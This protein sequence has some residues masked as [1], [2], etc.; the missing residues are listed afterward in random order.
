MEYVD[1]PDL[2][3]VLKALRVRDALMPIPLV[4]YI[5]AELAAALDVAHSACDEAG[6]PLGIV[7]RDVSPANVLLSRSG[8]VK[9]TDF[10][11]AAARVRATR[12]E[13][14]RLRGTFPYI[15]PEQAG[16]E[17][18]DGRSDVYAV[19]TLLF[20]LLTGT[21]AFD[22]DS[23]VEI[24]ARVRRGERPAL[25]DLRPD[26]PSAVCALVDRALA[27]EPDKRVSSAAEL[28][29][30]LLALLSDA[31]VNGRDD[32]SSWLSST[33]P[34]GQGLGVT[35]AGPNLDDI[36]NAQ[37]DAGAVVSPTGSRSRPGTLSAS[38]G[39]R[40]LM[41]TP[42]VPRPRRRL[43]GVAAALTVLAVVVV[44]WVFRSQT[45]ELQVT[46][47]PSGADVFIDGQPAGVSSM[48]TELRRGEYQ[49]TLRMDGYEIYAQTLAFGDDEALHVDLTPT[50]PNVQFD[51]V[52]PGAEVRV[53]DGPWFPA[54]N[55]ARAP[56]GRDVRIA[57]RLAGHA[58]IIEERVRF[59]P[60]D[61]IFTR[62]LTRSPVAAAG[63]S[64]P[65]DL[66]LADARLV[67]AQRDARSPIS[68]AGSRTAEPVRD[69]GPERQRESVWRL[70]ELPSDASITLGGVPVDRSDIRLAA[71]AAS[72]DLVI[73]RP[74]FSEWRRTLR[75]GEGGR[76]DVTW[77][78]VAPEPGVIVVRFVE[79]PFVGD[80]RIN[81]VDE[82][83]SRV[84]REEFTRPPGEYTVNVTHE[85]GR[86]DSQTVRVRSGTETIF[87]VDWN[88]G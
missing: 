23:D 76:L 60:L 68:E 6:E 72:A 74:G 49:L 8:E 59:Q 40:Q 47:A 45:S 83:R 4:L 55:T 2:R 25:L 50:W 26:L 73:A 66:A 39:T 36:L 18:V 56:V 57:M 44:A 1:G 82:G 84:T 14:G 63:S 78:E 10:G 85:S 51:S 17:T 62:T 13:T 77:P 24:L 80:I 11:I 27:T 69:A 87:P 32:L 19:G 31:G 15:S 54:G 46:T 16:G 22:G 29:S 41:I 65:D 52:P 7:H 3:R 20:E 38:S 35:A 71:D 75:S 53:D 70:P 64:S 33:F 9:L 30:Q 37:L 67:A 88:D 61:R 12:T 34:D 43:R 5:A 48:R 58:P 42:S 28:R 79:L 81:D 21:R 86:T